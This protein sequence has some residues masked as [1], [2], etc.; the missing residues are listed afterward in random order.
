[1]R[2]TSIFTADSTY[3]TT[4]RLLY[5]NSFPLDERRDEKE[6]KRVN[7]NKNY[8]YDIVLNGEEF[9]GIALY[10]ETPTLLFLEHLAIVP[11]KRNLGIGAKIL[12]LLKGK[13]KTVLLEIEPPKD[14]ISIRRLGFYER[15][16]FKLNP[17][18]HIQA[19]LKKGDGD[20]EL[21]ILTYP[22]VISEK[23]YFAFIEYMNMEI[24]A[25]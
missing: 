16:G 17:Y 4:A 20:I 1:M 21:K 15:N 14:E 5:E 22:N 19:K 8:H 18:Y 11:E 25:E 9:L 23:E 12:D 6:Q 10:W 13:N 2:L 7:G 3:L 24:S